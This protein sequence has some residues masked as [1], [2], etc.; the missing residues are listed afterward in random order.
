M[1]KQ[2]FL[3]VTLALM[4]VVVLGFSFIPGCDRTTDG[5]IF[6]SED[7]GTTWDN[8]FSRV[9]PGRVTDNSA[10]T[11]LPDNANADGYHGRLDVDLSALAANAADVQV[12]LRHYEPNWDWWIAVDNL[13]V[14]DMAPP[15]G[16]DVAIFAEDFSAGLGRAAAAGDRQIGV[17]HTGQPVRPEQARVGD[18][19]E[20]D[21]SGEL[22]LG[23]AAALARAHGE[24][25]LALAGGGAEHA[26]G[27]ERAG[28]N[29]PLG[30]EVKPGIGR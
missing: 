28:G 15:Q 4:A 9:A 23:F 19:R 5:G 26:V 10:T 12:R 16:G 7:G 17:Q 29:L 14:D 11:R 6:K 20:V 21:L 18:R 8:A 13:L 27:F 25:K 1:S 2:I 3:G 30:G 24:A 22:G